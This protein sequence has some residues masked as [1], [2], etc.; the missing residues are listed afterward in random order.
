MLSFLRNICF[1]LFLSLVILDLIFVYIM[2]IFVFLLVVYLWIFVI[3]LLLDGLVILFLLM[4]VMYKIGFEVSK[5]SCFISFCCFL[6]NLIEWV[7][8][9]FLN[10]FFSL[11]R[12]LNLNIVFLFFCFVSLLM[13][14]ICFLI[15]F[16]LVRISLR[17]IVLMLLIGLIFLEMCVMLLLEKVWIM[18][19]IV[20]IWWMWERNL[21]LS[22]FFLD[23]FFMIFVILVNLKVVGIVFFGLISLVSFCRWLLGIF[24]IFMFGLIV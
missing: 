21:L 2:I 24:I 19:Y 7:G 8:F 16:I 1:L 9:L 10:V 23:V 3:F 17:L 12:I 4:F 5:W 15:V 6:V 13:C 18:W 14:V 20:L 11:D 22:F